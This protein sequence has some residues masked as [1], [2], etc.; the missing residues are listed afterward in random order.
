VVVTPD[1]QTA[2]VFSISSDLDGSAGGDQ[3]PDESGEAGAVSQEQIPQEPAFSPDGRWLAY[4]SDSDATG[5]SRCTSAVPAAGIRQSG[6]WQISNSVVIKLRCGRV[7][8]TICC[9]SPATRSWRELHGERRHVVADKPRV[10]L[11]KLGGGTAFGLAPDGKRV[12]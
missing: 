5:A 6:Q 2:G 4:I 3:R 12:A 10:W 8:A 11:A 7:P 1:G 9:T